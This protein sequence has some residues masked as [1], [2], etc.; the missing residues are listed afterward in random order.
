MSTTVVM[1]RS[2]TYALK[3][4]KLFLSSGIKCTVE[5]RPR[6]LS[7]N[8]CGYTLRIHADLDYAQNILKAAS[9]PMVDAFV[10]NDDA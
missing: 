10:E 6:N 3:G 8:G 5:R 4:Q 9:I 7:K 2:V 1:V